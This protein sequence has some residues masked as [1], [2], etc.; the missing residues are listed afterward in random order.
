MNYNTNLNLNS[1]SSKVLV[2]SKIHHLF[3]FRLKS[4]LT[5]KCFFLKPGRPSFKIFFLNNRKKCGILKDFRRSLKDD[6]LLKIFFL[7]N[8]PCSANL[9]LRDISSVPPDIYHRKQNLPLG[10]IQPPKSVNIICLQL[11]LSIFFSQMPSSQCI[12]KV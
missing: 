5:K 12:S 3:I 10:E 11:L 7:S 9:C 2:L 6:P 8:I 1:H 4:W